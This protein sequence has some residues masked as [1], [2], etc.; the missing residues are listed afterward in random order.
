M[1]IDTIRCFIS[2]AEC[3]N[4]TRAAAKEHI[5]Q[6]AMSRKISSLEKELDVVLLYRDTRQVELTVAGN[7]FYL[8]AQELL[9]LYDT[10]VKQVKEAQ[11]NF[12]TEL[13]L[14][15]GVYDHVLLNNFLE[16]YAAS[17]PEGLKLSCMQEP[18]PAL[19]RDFEERLI[20]VMI[21]TDQYEE[22]L[23]KLNARQLGILPI[24][25]DPWYLVLHR[26]HPLARYDVVPMKL[27]RTETL[28]TMQ[29][30]NLEHVKGVFIDSFPLKDF[31]FVNSFDSKLVMANAGL[32]FALSPPFMFPVADR[33]QNIVLRKTDP[34]YNARSFAAYYWK[35]NPNPLVTDFIDHYRAHLEA[36]PLRT[37]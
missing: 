35:D 23:L 19:A 6:T 1:N 16:E 27:L 18:Y 4:F 8:K 36:N 32:G 15:V 30:G 9:K 17:A 5:T 31:L 33:Y 26:D 13:K 10:A 7:E 34:P 2:L 20:D 11:S 29:R 21:S 12:R 25:H 3:L 37:N 14:G 24:Y 22:D 28:L